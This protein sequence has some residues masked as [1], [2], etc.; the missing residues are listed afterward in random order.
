MK[1]I[2]IIAFTAVSM[3]GYGQTIDI[4]KARNFLTLTGGTVSSNDSLV[5]KTD[6]TVKFKGIDTIKHIHNYVSSVVMQ[7]E[8]WETKD[9]IC[10][11]CLRNCTATESRQWIKKVDPY[12][13]TKERLEQYFKNQ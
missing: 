13:V 9:I 12:R 4:V 8:Q 3:A 2:L 1:Y 5:Y 7:G 6:T 11:L 10:T